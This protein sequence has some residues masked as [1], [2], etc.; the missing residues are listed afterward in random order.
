MIGH[1]FKVIERVYAK[2]PREEL[3]GALGQCERC[4]VYLDWRSPGDGPILSEERP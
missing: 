3:L 1:R 2:S 4:D